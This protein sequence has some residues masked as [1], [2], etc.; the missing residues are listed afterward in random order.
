MQD[1]D[2]RYAYEYQEPSPPG[3]EWN[4]S[5]LFVGD[6]KLNRPVDAILETQALGDLNYTDVEIT[7]D[8]P[9]GFELIGGDTLWKGNPKKDEKINLKAKVK[10]KEVG[11]WK[12]TGNVR[13]NLL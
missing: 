9:D 1:Y 13:K 5:I 4:I 6:P 2:Q 3:K 10:I 12:V 11:D 7:L 8:F